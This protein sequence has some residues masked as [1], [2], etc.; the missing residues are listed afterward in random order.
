[1]T[2]PRPARP[3]P[4]AADL[5]HAVLLRVAEFLRKLPAEQLADLAEGTARLEVVPKGW[6]VVAPGAGSTSRGS[7]AAA[8][9]P[10]VS[11]EEVKADLVVMTDRSAAASYLDGLKL[12]VAQFK[13]LA[14]DL[15]IA[16]R[17]GAKKDELRD[18]I[19]TWTVGRRLDSERISRPAP[20]Y[21]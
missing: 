21:R 2:D 19:V 11:A 18:A 12:T 4:D 13:V 17:S 16:V 15:D 7:R 9:R 1:V 14:K 5:T 3:N 8:A 6:R 10:A 20:S